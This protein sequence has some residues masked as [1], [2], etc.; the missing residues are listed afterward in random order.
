MLDA[1]RAPAERTR[2]LEHGDGNAA[3]RECDRS[4]HACVAAADHGY[5]HCFEFQV[6]SSRL[7]KPET[8]R[9]KRETRI[10][11]S[12]PEL[13]GDPFPGC[14]AMTRPHCPGNE[15]LAFKYP[16]RRAHQRRAAQLLLA[17]GE[18]DV[19]VD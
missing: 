16:A 14:G 2:R 13:R 17:A 10:R 3:F 8:R 9:V 18:I 11:N 12:K 15:H 1:P 4:G 7:R 5:F 19:E 6:S